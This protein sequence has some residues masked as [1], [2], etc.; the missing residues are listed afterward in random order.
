M[1][2]RGDIFPSILQLNP[3]SGLALAKPRAQITQSFS[4]A[5]LA[6]ASRGNLPIAGWEAEGPFRAS[7]Q[8]PSSLCCTQL[9]DHSTH[10]P[11]GTPSDTPVQIRWVQSVCPTANIPFSGVTN[12]PSMQ[13]LPLQKSVCISLGHIPADP[14]YCSTGTGT[15]TPQKCPKSNSASPLAQVEAHTP[16]T[17]GLCPLGER[18]LLLNPK[19]MHLQSISHMHYSHCSPQAIKHSS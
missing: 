8:Q 6:F 3:F 7:L 9:W 13:I 5:S 16:W 4:R 14:T 12:P 11:L 15:R 17:G 2:T 18:E 19:W 1:C 10:R